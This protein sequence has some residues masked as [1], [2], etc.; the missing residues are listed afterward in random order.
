MPEA[1]VQFGKRIKSRHLLL[2]L[3]V[4]LYVACLPRSAISLV[5][6]RCSDWTGW[7]ILLLGW[8]GIYWLGMELSFS[9]ANMTWL[10]NPVL[11]MA[12]MAL[13]R[14]RNLRARCL[15]IIALLIGVFIFFDPKV[16]TP[17]S[18]D[19]SYRVTGEPPCQIAGYG[20][21]YWL[22]LAS[23]ATACVAGLVG[24][25]VREG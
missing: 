8:L 17:A 5:G 19:L 14:K 24:I 1:V 16:N 9:P 13:Y 21:G 10:A 22:W 7:E 15:S 25:I 18:L 20:I 3:S 4:A 2:V 11:F 12:W 23:M 6:P